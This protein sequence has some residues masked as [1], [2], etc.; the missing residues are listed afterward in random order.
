MATNALERQAL[1]DGADIAD[2]WVVPEPRTDGAIVGFTLTV[3]GGHHFA[4]ASARHVGDHLA[5][6]VDGQ[7]VGTPPQ[8]RSAIERHGQIE[9]DKTERS[10]AED[11]AL[12][13]R[14]GP[15]PAELRVTA[16]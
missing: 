9:M 3:A 2:A 11:L 14:T 10:H 8:L 1:L 7:V 6:V 4:R 15:L 5:M 12:I 16:R 13:L